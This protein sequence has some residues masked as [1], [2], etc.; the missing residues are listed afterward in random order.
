MRPIHPGEILREEY[1]EPLGLSASALARELHVPTNRVTEIL[2]AERSVTA[3][4]ALR[5]ARCLRTTPEF[6]MNLQVA[7][8][9]RLAEVSSA[10][11]V[12]SEV[13]PLPM[14]A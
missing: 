5:L 3:E 13:K 4:T 12:A 9:L 10:D 1:L 14:T 6:W 11:K 8:E 2:S 7:Y